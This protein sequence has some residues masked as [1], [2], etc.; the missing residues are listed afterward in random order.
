MASPPYRSS[1]EV[2]VYADRRSMGEAAARNIQ[3]IVEK[4]VG[5]R[6]KARVIF[7]CAPSQDDLYVALVRLAKASPL[8]WRKVEAFHMDDY[9]GLDGMHPQS[10]RTYLRTHFLSQV[11]VAVFHPLQGEAPDGDAEAKRYDA[12]LAEAPIDAIALGIGENGHLAFNDPPVA[13]FDDPVGVKTV[14]LDAICRGQQVNDGCFPRLEDVPRY[15][16]T[17]TLPVFAA[18]LN[19]SCVVPTKRKAGAVRAALVGPIDT[20]CP[21][22]LLRKHPRAKLFL[23]ADAAS[24]LPPGFLRGNGT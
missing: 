13:D 1:P 14:E 3:S 22:T 6:G 20:E 9:L 21:A 5:D 12:L 4:A 16:L 10:F 2:L 8:I 17:V 18:A 23:D 15:A 19:L 11:K 24:L 7:A